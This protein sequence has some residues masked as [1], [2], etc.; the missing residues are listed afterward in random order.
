VVTEKAREVIARFPA[1]QLL[2]AGQRHYMVNGTLP[3]TRENEAPPAPAYAKW[4]GRV[5][6]RNVWAWAIRKPE[7]V[8]KRPLKSQKFVT[9]DNE[10]QVETEQ[11]C[12]SAW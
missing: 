6:G 1:E 8:A 10:R 2:V 4:L 7:L 9:R 12:L 3:T 5:P 11:L